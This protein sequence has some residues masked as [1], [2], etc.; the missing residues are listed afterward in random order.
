M[1]CKCEDGRI[2]YYK[3][4]GSDSKYREELLVVR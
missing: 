3:F 1:R 2:E 4:S